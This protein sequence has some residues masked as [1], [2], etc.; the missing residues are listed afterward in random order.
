MPQ[1]IPKKVHSNIQTA[2]MF[3]VWPQ[4]IDIQL[5]INPVNCFT[6]ISEI[7]VKIQQALLNLNWIL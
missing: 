3:T 2:L 6:I 7:W 5:I 1:C 4:K